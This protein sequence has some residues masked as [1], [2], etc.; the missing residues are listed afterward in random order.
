MPRYVLAL[1]QGTTSSRAILFDARGAVV[2]IDQHEFTQ[3][4]PKPGWVEHDP[5]E[6]WETQLRAARGALLAARAKA[7]DVAAIGITNQRETTVVWD[8][9]TGRPI[10]RAIVWQ[11]RQTADLCAELRSRGLEEEV[12]RRTG[13]VID[14]YF[15]ATKVR[16]ILDAVPGAQARAERGE[17]AFG[18]IDSWLLHRLTGGRVHATE[19]SNASRTMLWDIHARDW[20]ERLLAELRIPR[21]LL[22][23]V[24]DSSGAFGETEPE[25]LGGAVPIAGMAGDQQAALF[26]QGCFT[27]GSAKNTYGTGCFLLMNTGSE[28]PLSKS[29]LVTTVAWGLGGA[30]EYALEGSIFVAGAAVQWLRD[31]LGLVASA[32]ETEAAA[33]SVE[34]TG[35]VYLVPAFV[36]LGAPYWDE[37]ARGLLVGLTRG[38]SRAHV[39]RAALEAIAYQ[40]RDVVDC[41]R[42]DAGLALDVLRVDG[43]ACRN[44]FLMQFQ[45][46]VLGVPVRR[47]PVLEVTALGAAALAGLAVGF[48]RDRSEL[49]AATGQGAVRFEPRMSADR[50]EALYAGWLRAVERSRGWVE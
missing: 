3:H 11:S 10:H 34:D 31:G 24:R 44:D 30:V 2:A 25:W 12:R 14:A 50:R 27:P 29:G 43:G 36:G 21:A 9:A 22:P 20:S 16:F 23:E 42:R 38:T 41:F 39:V 45:A 5:D 49:G 8:R 15:S 17:L 33:H 13:L 1:D 37:R 40:S 7:A 35:G 48:W 6:I 4:F 19:P 28:A 46:D 18:T 47:P 32:V 26:G